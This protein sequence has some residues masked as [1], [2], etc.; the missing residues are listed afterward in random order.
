M[1]G[2]LYVHN[3]DLVPRANLYGEQ[4]D[5]KVGVVANQDSNLVKILDSIGIHSDGKW[6]V[7]SL[8]IPHSLNN[9]DGMFSRIPKERFKKRESI[10]QAEF[11]R[12]MKTSSGNLSAIEAVKGE[13]LRGESAYLILKNTDTTETK[14]FKIDINMTKNR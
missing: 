2:D 11:L 1:G 3:S 7:E 13:S 8:T 12:N 14:L 6:E 9:P 4:R 5:V 10:W